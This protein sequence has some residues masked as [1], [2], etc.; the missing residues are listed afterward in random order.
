M[1]ISSEALSGTSAVK[2]R[3][4][5]QAVLAVQQRKQFKNCLGQEVSKPQ[6]EKT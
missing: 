2:G 5:A 4:L 6:N 3:R 1:P